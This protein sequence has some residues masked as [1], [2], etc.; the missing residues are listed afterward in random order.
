LTNETVE[1]ARGEVSDLHQTTLRM[2]CRREPTADRAGR[3]QVHFIVVGIAL[4]TFVED[5]H[6]L[7]KANR[8]SN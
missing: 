8:W 2:I 1:A 3:T 6:Q 5:P 7:K 4:K